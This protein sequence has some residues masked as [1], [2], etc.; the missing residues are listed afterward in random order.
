MLKSM[1]RKLASLLLAVLVALGSAPITTLAFEWDVSGD[2][3]IPEVLVPERMPDGFFDEV[4][5]MR[6]FDELVARNPEDYAYDILT[7]TLNEPVGMQG[8]E[9]QYAINSPDEMVEIVVQFVTP[10]AVALRQMQERGISID[11]ILSGY[12]YVEQ[13]QSAHDAFYQQLAEITAPMEIHVKHYWLFNGVYMR[14]PGST[15]PLIAELPEVYGVFPNVAV[16]M[17]ETTTYVDITPSYVEI[18]PAFISPNFMREAREYHQINYVHNEMGLT[19][20]GVRVAVIDTGIYHNH[21]EFANFLDPATNRIRGWQLDNGVTIGDN[22]HGT[23]VSGA[24]IGIA[25]GVELWHWR[26]PPTGGIGCIVTAGVT[27]AHQADMDIINLSTYPRTVQWNHTNIGFRNAVN[28]AVLDGI[29]VVAGAGNYYDRGVSYSYVAGGAASLAITVGASRNPNSITEYSSRGSIPGTH[30]IK[31]DIIAR[32]SVYS[33]TI[34]GGYR[35]VGGTSHASP[36]IAGIVAMMI[37][38]NPDIPKQDRPHYIKSMLMNTASPMLGTGGDSVFTTGAGFVRPIAALGANTVVYTRH[39]VVDIIDQPNSIQRMSSLSYGRVNTATFP[40]TNNTLPL[41]IRN[42]A[43]TSREFTISYRFNPNGNP[44]NG[45]S[46]RLSNNRVTVAAGGTGSIDV[47]LILGAN[48]LADRY[49]EGFIYVYDGAT[50]VARVPFAGFCVV[51]D[52]RNIVSNEVELRNAT[53]S[54]GTEPKTIYLANDIILR[55]ILT[56]L[57]IHAESNITLKSVDE[58]MYTLYAGDDMDVIIVMSEAR[59]TIA[60]IAISR[61][62]NTFGRGIQNYGYFTLLNGIISGHG[63]GNII[64]AG[65]LNYG[66]FY[67]QG[68]SI[69]NNIAGVGGAGVYISQIG[70]F[71][72]KGGEIYNNMV[73]NSTASG[74]GVLNHGGTFRMY[75]GNIINNIGGG[76]GGGVHL[77][78]A[79]TFV[80]IDGEITYNVARNGGGVSIASDS[81]S[82]FNAEG[83]KIAKNSAGSNIGDGGGIWVDINDLRSGALHIGKNVVFANNHTSISSPFKARLEIDDTVYNKFIQGTRWTYPFTQGFNNVDIFYAPAGALESSIRILHF[84]LSGTPTNVTEPQNIDSIR[85]AS[86]TPL[87]HAPSFPA[88]DPESG[89]NYTFVGWYLNA[90]FTQPVTAATLMPN[91][92]NTILHARWENTS[93]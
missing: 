53:A 44:N 70:N 46:I 83:G 23:T 82:S 71:T 49:Y 79:A 81:G 42:R 22:A 14:V 60:G 17:P 20:A 3:Y 61:S 56:P 47:S 33:T 26:N 58:A 55:E 86:N 69:R 67:M 85:V 10:P 80:M 13:A 78:Q 35:S 50:H 30:H 1:V 9:G 65:V 66:T 6:G 57:Y 37:E 63:H 31:P 36:I 87:K 48:A 16:D 72:M 62:N 40:T 8:F 34:G 88:F 68:G 18:A 73:L 89:G 74:G 24:L 90:S 91:N 32:S 93:R 52:P 54:A 64:G 12:T 2:Y 76:W 75:N 11:L 29:V 92:D 21:P 7:S 77:K 51:G 28:L 59:L 38:A 19:G 45:G 27:R 25:P 5:G 43:N 84:H 41:Y 39:S 15:I 4:V